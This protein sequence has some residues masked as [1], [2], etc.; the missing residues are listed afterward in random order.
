MI[1]GGGGEKKLFTF[2]RILILGFAGTVKSNFDTMQ[3]RCLEQTML[4]K[5]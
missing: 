2:A 4:L 3:K 1:W 5:I